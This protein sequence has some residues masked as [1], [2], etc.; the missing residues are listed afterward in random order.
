MDITWY[1]QACF[2]IKGKTA[3]VVIDPFTPEKAGIKLPKLAADVVLVTHNHEDHNYTQA[4]TEGEPVIIAGPGEYEVKGCTIVG[5][6]TF[7][8]PNQGQERGKNTVYQIT[9]DGVSIVHLGDLGHTLTKDQVS[10]IGVCDIVM[11]PVGGNYTIEASEAA[12]VVTQLEPSIIIPMHYA[13]DGLKYELAPLQKFLKEIGK[14]DAQPVAKLTITK[15][16]LPDE[17]AV[18]VLEKQ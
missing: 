13:I 6:Q 7:H 2:K 10:A 9:V 1:G 3:S 4:V 12:E 15:D 5:V 16:K 17:P 18:V 14:E 8:D 11:V